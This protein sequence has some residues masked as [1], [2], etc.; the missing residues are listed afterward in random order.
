M[1][2]AGE[3]GE[4]LR[5]PNL[6]F[7]SSF[8]LLCNDFAA[9]GIDVISPLLPSA[10]SPVFS[11]LY[12]ES[13]VLKSFEAQEKLCDPGHQVCLTQTCS[14]KGH[15]SKLLIGDLLRAPSCAGCEGGMGREDSTWS[16]SLA[17]LC[18]LG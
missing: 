12:Y 2:V 16:S 14:R 18:L 10:N 4:P 17:G 8:S 13:H 15:V 11:V 9:R 6:T 1:G 3:P 5:A 7:F